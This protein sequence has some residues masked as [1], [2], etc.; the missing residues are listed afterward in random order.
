M[1]PSRFTEEQIIG[2][3]REQEA[4]GE[5]GRCVPQA[6]GQQRD[7]LQVESEVRWPRRFGRQAATRAR[8]REHQ[9]KNNLTD[10]VHST[11]APW[12]KESPPI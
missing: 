12:D 10:K 1:K 7:V 8:G 5:D 9:W 4:G 2:I 6:R 3:L 11:F